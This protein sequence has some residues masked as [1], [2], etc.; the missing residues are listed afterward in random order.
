M[1]SVI[2]N[3]LNITFYIFGKVGKV[4]FEIKRKIWHLTLYILLVPHLQIK[5]KTQIFSLMHITWDKITLL[6]NFIDLF[7]IHVK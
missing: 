5:K 2:Q 4:Q 6:N 3:A 7:R 1:N